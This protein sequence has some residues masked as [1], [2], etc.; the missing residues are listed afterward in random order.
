M[1]A[2]E[3][4]VV[5]VHVGEEVVVTLVHAVL[6]IHRVAEGGKISHRTRL[7]HHRGE[8]DV[9][10]TVDMMAAMTT[11]MPEWMVVMA[12]TAVTATV[13]NSDASHPDPPE[14]LAPNKTPPRRRVFLFYLSLRLR[15]TC[16]YCCLKES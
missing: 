15:A 4:H 2:V 12:V 13:T 1:V 16:V 3:V 14:K 5:V 10:E 6:P 9:V 7:E 8:V 11:G